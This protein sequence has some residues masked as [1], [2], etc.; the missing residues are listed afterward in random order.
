MSNSFLLERQDPRAVA[1]VQ[2]LIDRTKDG[3]VK[4]TRTPTTYET[5]LQDGT[6][7]AFVA[8]PSHLI[9]LAPNWD[10]FSIRKKDGQQIIKI[11][12]SLSFLVAISTDPMR[13]TLNE[14]FALVTQKGKDDLDAILGELDKT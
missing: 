7:V 5:D 1:I 13:T 2:K 9:A 14:L 10:Q 11:E 12:N 6:T 3:R 4:W 8:A